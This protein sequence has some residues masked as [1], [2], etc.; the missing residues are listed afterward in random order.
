MAKI[1]KEAALA[2]HAEGKPGICSPPSH[3]RHVCFRRGPRA[4][5]CHFI[6]RHIYAMANDILSGWRWHAIMLCQCTPRHR[7]C[8][9]TAEVFRHLLWNS[10]NSVKLFPWDYS[11]QRSR[12]YLVG[13]PNWTDLGRSLV[14]EALPL[15]CARKKRLKP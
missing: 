6:Y 12:G 9:E 10:H 2:Y 4:L 3:Y 1:T 7:R 13:I 8:E 11:G 14:P 5:Q 15:P